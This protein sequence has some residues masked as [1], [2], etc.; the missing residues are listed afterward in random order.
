MKQFRTFFIAMALS[1]GTIGISWAQAED[2]QTAHIASQELIE[3]MPAFITASNEMEQLR[4]SYA[5]QVEN[6]M[7]EYKVKVEKYQAESQTKTN[8]ENQTRALELQ[9]MKAKIMD[10][11][12]KSYEQMQQKKRELM[13]PVYEKARA[14]IQ[15]VARAKGYEYVLDSTTGT[16]VLLA[17]GYNLMP[18]VK[19]ELGIE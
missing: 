7:K 17:D 9:E 11:Q 8:E 4:A 6:M 2:S 3:M 18:D 14:A 5:T 12:Q 19:K 10:Y 13:K 16:G 15:K 1:M